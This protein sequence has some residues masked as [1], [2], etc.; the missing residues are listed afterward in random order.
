MYKLQVSDSDFPCPA[1]MVFVFHA[2][3]GAAES[4]DWLLCS[5]QEPPQGTPA[6]AKVCQTQSA[7]AAAASQHHCVSWRDPLDVL[8]CQGAW[9]EAPAAWQDGK[10]P[11]SQSGAFR[12]TP[13]TSV[14]CIFQTL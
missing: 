8:Q 3:T 9:E 4:R 5:T 10:T 12:I 6:T 11:D 13:F 7:A 2:G 1:M 14:L